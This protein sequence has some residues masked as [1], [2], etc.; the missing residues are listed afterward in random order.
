VAGGAAVVRRLGDAHRARRAGRPPDGPPLSDGDPARRVPPRGDRA[1]GAAPPGRHAGAPRSGG[2]GLPRDEP[3]R[4]R[5]LRR[6]SPPR[7]PRRLMRAMLLRAQ[8]PI[9]TAPLGATALPTPGPGPGGLRVRVR[10]CAT[11]RTAM[12]V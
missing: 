3:P 9:A 12:H 8:A 6:A 5:G 11:C 1:A 10:A 4:L 7:R 2:G